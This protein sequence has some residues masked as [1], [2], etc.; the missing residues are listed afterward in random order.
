LALRAIATISKF[1]VCCVAAG[2]SLED[3]HTSAEET[4]A[5]AD[6][7]ERSA[8]AQLARLSSRLAKKPSPNYSELS[9]LTT[10]HGRT[11]LS[12]L[13]SQ[14]VMSTS[15]VPAMVDDTSLEERVADFFGFTKH[16]DGWTHK[17]FGQERATAVVKYCDEQS[18]VDIV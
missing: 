12:R 17:T 8:A 14:R 9:P 2:K 10:S 18:Y 4:S 16:I 3:I 11:T 13:R 15:G 1:I 5:L 6:R 7:V